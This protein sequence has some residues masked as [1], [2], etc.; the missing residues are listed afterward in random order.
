[1]KDPFFV[2]AQ[3]CSFFFVKN[4]RRGALNQMQNCNFLCTFLIYYCHRRR[5]SSLF[6][7]QCVTWFP[8]PLNF[9]C[10]HINLLFVPAAHSNPITTVIIPLARLLRMISAFYSIF[11]LM[12][13]VS[14]S[15]RRMANNPPH[16]RRFISFRGLLSSICFLMHFSDKTKISENVSAKACTICPFMGGCNARTEFYK[17]FFW[18]FTAS[19]ISIGTHQSALK[20]QKILGNSIQNTQNDWFHH[21][22]SAAL[23]IKSKS[24]LKEWDENGN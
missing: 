6:E 2:L 22:E 9:V 19:A 3:N 1:M 14:S 8:S 12:H 17:N 20:I 11:L 15:S 18:M 24:V 7:S 4:T 13:F 10:C 21:K 16:K 5:F 23:S